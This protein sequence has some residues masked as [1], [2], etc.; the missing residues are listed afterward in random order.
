[1]DMGAPGARHGMGSE[2]FGD[3]IQASPCGVSLSGLRGDPGLAFQRFR[4]LPHGTSG[5]RL[6]ALPCAAARGCGAGRW[7]VQGVFGNPGCRGLAGRGTPVA[8]QGV[9]SVFSGGFNHGA[10]S[11]VLLLGLAADRAVCSAFLTQ[12]PTSLSRLRLPALPCCAVGTSLPRLSALPCPLAQSGDKGLGWNPGETIWSSGRVCGWVGEVL[13][14]SVPAAQVTGS[15][16]THFGLF[17]S[18]FPCAIVTA[19]LAK[20]DSSG[21]DTHVN[22]GRWVLCRRRRIPRLYLA[23]VLPLVER[24]EASSGEP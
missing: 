15:S 20:S 9:G 24:G 5:P 1:M 19:D 16:D 3:L 14:R 18:G 6:S 13:W 2:F 23:T 8:R 12:I 22:G 7:G 10:P 21:A 4:A 11:G 17:G